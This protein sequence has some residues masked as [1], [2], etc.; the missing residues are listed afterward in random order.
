[1][2]LTAAE[3]WSRILE[4]AKTAL[5]EQAF[6]TWLAPTQAVAVSND[7]LVVSTPNPFAVD[8]VE[9]KYAGLL[10][11]IG[12]HLFGR[13]FTLSVQFQGNGK[14]ASVPPIDLAPAPPP[15]APART[16]SAPHAHAGDTRPLPPLNP[17]YVF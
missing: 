3:I 5:P 9:D 1:M 13:R 11:S 16:E 17:R 4:S 12:E 7:L 2:E 8:W 6:R 15:A 10:T 14:A